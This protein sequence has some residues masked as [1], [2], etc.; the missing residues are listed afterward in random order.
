M[1]QED[2]SI[3]AEED[4]DGKL[5]TLLHNWSWLAIFDWIQ[6]G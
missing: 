2:F 5:V 6:L 3:C 1:L 4:K